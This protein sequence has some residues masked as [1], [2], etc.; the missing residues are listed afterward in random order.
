MRHSKYFE[1]YLVS[2][3]SESYF[4]REAINHSSG[5]TLEKAQA[6]QLIKLTLLF[7]RHFRCSNFVNS[8]TYRNVANYFILT[9]FL[10]SPE[11]EFFS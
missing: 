8:S 7:L 4:K 6:G 1:S 11:Q 9:G 3:V 5:V 2:A 10:T